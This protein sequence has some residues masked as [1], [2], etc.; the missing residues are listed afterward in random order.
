MDVLLVPKIAI[1]D[2]PSFF[3]PYCFLVSN[4]I[5]ELVKSHRNSGSQIFIYICNSQILIT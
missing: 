2:N 3:I 5:E 1:P 4:Y